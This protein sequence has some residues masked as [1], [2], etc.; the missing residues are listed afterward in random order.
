MCDTYPIHL[1]PTGMIIILTNDEEHWSWS[2]SLDIFLHFPVTSPSSSTYSLH[3]PELMHCQSLSSLTQ[4]DHV[5]HP[6][7]ERGKTRECNRT[8]GPL[9]VEAES[10]RQSSVLWHRAVYRVCKLPV[11]GNTLPSSST[12]KMED[13]ETTRFHCP[14]ECNRNLQRNE[15]LETKA[16]ITERNKA[17]A[18]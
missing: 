11:F 18:V 16:C 15:G 13:F 1:I 17:H 14:E 2:S 10:I 12:V 8:S 9:Q 7:K 6:N 5:T 4:C 3:R